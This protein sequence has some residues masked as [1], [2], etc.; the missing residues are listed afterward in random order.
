LSD[1]PGQDPERTASALALT[2][3]LDDPGSPIDGL[4]PR[5]ARLEVASA[6][7]TF[8]SALARAGPAIVVI[9]DLHWADPAMLDLVE[10]LADRLESAVMFLGSARREL[11]AERPGW[12]GRSRNFTSIMLEPLGAG[13]S[14]RLLGF[15]LDGA[16]DEIPV[17]VRGRILERAGGNPFFLEQIVRRLVEERGTARAQLDTWDL[18]NLDIP[19]RSRPC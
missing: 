5:Q 17:P 10:E 2:V 16:Q 6:W 12:G 13:D 11:S 8:F 3:G 19:T 14:E 18:E 7:R 4:E 15:L 9:H 1:R